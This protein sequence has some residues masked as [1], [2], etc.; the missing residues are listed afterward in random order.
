MGYMMAGAVGGLLAGA[1]ALLLVFRKWGEQ[2]Q[3]NGVLV[4]V[5]VIGLVVG[6]LVGGA[7]GVQAIIYRYERARKRQK[8]KR[9]KGKDKRRR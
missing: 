8:E 5:V 3:D 7:Y 2:I 6:G 9:G 4:L 1:A